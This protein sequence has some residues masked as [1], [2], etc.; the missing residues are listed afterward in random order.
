MKV[1]AL[2]ALVTLNACGSAPTITYENQCIHVEVWGMCQDYKLVSRSGNSFIIRSIDPSTQELV[3]PQTVDF[4][5]VRQYKN[6]SCTDLDTNQE[7][8]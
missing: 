6:I 1:L 3:D 8:R 5:F 7:G 2:L 4:N